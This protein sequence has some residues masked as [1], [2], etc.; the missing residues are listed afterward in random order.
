M[1]KKLGKIIISGFFILLPIIITIWV[2]T[3]LFDF[4]DGILKGYVQALTGY[5][6]PGIG[7]IVILIASFLL[8]LISNYILG[9]EFIHFSEEIINKLPI[10]NTVHASVKK[11]NEVLFLQ[12]GR[13]V[14]R[15]VCAVEYPRKG[16]WSIGFATGEGPGE[17]KARKKKKFTCVFIPN[18]PAPATGFTIIVPTKEVMFLNMSVEDAFKIIVSGGAISK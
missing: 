3:I 1:L 5:N 14:Q 16:I 11:M 17:L 8:G 6:I 7:I 2:L 9:K 13:D 18:T 15:R 12:K 10:V 4:T